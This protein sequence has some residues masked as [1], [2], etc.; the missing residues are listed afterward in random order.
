M[1]TL[2]LHQGWRRR[3]GDDVAGVLQFLLGIFVLHQPFG[4]AIAAHVDADRGVA[5]AGEIGMRQLSR[6]MVPS[7][8]R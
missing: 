7:R 5:V 2:P 3:P 6:A 8:L 1:P 4:I